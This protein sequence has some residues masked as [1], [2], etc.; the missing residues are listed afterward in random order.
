MELITK[1]T[2][3]RY[4]AQRTISERYLYCHTQVFHNRENEFIDHLK[5]IEKTINEN[6]KYNVLNVF[7]ILEELKR[8]GVKMQYFDCV[9]NKRISQY[10]TLSR[11]QKRNQ[12]EFRAALIS[13]KNN[14]NHY[15]YLRNN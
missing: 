3:N 12:T 8:L 7:G 13:L 10:P 15:I 11:V 6:L 14:I 4:I 1:C 5:F 2:I 9:T